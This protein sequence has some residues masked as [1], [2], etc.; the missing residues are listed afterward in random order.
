[1][2]IPVPIARTDLMQQVIDL[3]AR[4]GLARAYTKLV[5]TGGYAADG[6]TPKDSNL[7]IIQ[8]DD[9]PYRPE[10]YQNG[11]RLLLNR[12]GRD[13][14]KIKTLNYANVL[15]QR[16]VLQDTGALDILYHDGRHVFESSRANFFLFDS[17]GRLHTSGANTLEGVTRKHVIQTA[18]AAGIVLAQGP[19]RLD[20]IS[21]AREAFITSTTKG[22]LPVTM[23]NDLTISE[24]KVGSMTL[25][26]HHMF[27]DYMKEAAK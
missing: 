2:R 4:N 8:H 26:L 3:A 18:R 16:Q 6:F 24:G 1:M 13:K 10:D 14:P 15:R 7:L 11:I 22:V 27:E 12:Y 23:V 17:E 20:M 19:M 5:L 9:I 21:S 25:E